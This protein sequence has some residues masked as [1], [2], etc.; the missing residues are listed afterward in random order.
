M[1]TYNCFSTS[2][3]GGS[4]VAS[5]LPL[6]DANLSECNARVALCAVADGHGS[7]KYFR[8]DV[9]ARL[10]CQTAVNKLRHFV[11]ANRDYQALSSG[12][13]EKLW[14][15]RMAIL[16]EWQQQT[17]DYT[18]LHPFTDSDLAAS[19]E[20]FVARLDYDVRQPYGTTLLAAAVTSD[21][22][23]CIKLGDGEATVTCNGITQLLDFGD[24][25][26]CSNFTYSMCG[27]DAA[28]RMQI[29]YYP[30]DGVTNVA[31]GL[32]TDGLS[33][34][35]ADEATL[36]RVMD[37]YARELATDKQTA[38]TAIAE[39]LQTVSTKSYSKDDVSVAFVWADCD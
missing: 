22:C 19:S 34:A 9:G 6:Q 17:E 38:T 32:C 31:L 25:E 10:A 36:V 20:D 14:R 23:L 28:E 4:H 3:R 37:G 15:L 29:R 5:G 1:T 33:G 13:D 16:A 21:Y 7:A 26:L 30:L 39:Q 35:L 11:E 27:D 8:S 18:R 2:V 24:D 12:V